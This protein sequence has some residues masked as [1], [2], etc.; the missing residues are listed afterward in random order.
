MLTT[1]EYYELKT[2]EYRDA[3]DRTTIARA[4]LRLALTAEKSAKDSNAK[5]KST[6]KRLFPGIK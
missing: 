4:N 2:Q 6:Y 3:R 5:A 1:Q